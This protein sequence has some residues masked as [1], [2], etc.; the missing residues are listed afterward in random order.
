MQLQEDDSH[1]ADRLWAEYAR[2]RDAR[3]RA[4][5]IC[6]FTPLAHSLARRFIRPGMAG[7]DLAQVALL[8]LVKAADRFDPGAGVRFV[9]F[10]TPTILG[11][12]RH[13]LRDNGWALHVPRSLQEL[14]AQ[15]QR[16]E[17]EL[18]ERLGRR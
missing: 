7:E 2:T 1:R 18:G 14:A 11:E 4:A 17:A 3:A 10:A 5:I 6:Q 15:V 16:A 8:G 12:L 9:S 13:H